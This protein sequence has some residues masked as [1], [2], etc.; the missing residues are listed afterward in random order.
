MVYCAAKKKPMDH[1]LRNCMMVSAFKSVFLRL[2]AGVFALLLTGCALFTPSVDEPADVTSVPAAFRAGS[3]GALP[4]SNRWWEVF[5]DAELNR[6]IEV[7]L[8][9]NTTIAQ[10]EARLRQAYAT[11]R[12]LRD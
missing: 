11:A 9:N 2:V 5:G 7:A 8:T 4:M 1:D 12:K 3:G 6:L 10:A